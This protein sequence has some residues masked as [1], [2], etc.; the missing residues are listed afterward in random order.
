MKTA[1]KETTESQSKKCARLSPWLRRVL[2]AVISVAVGFG[3]YYGCAGYSGGGLPKP[4][5]V[6][7]A[8]VESGSMQSSMKVGDL[9]I[10][11]ERDEIAVGDVIVYRS[12]RMLVVHRVIAIDGDAI[13]TKGDANNTADTP[14]DKSAYEGTVVKRVPFI[15]MLLDGIKSPI[16]ILLLAA[17]AILIIELSRSGGRNSDEPTAEELRAEIEKLKRERGEEDT[18]PR[19]G[20]EDK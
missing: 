10:V 5:G 7:V 1:P 16:G 2:L 20:E 9:L 11:K 19:G 14:F 17:I 15:G 13:T 12:G 6:G 8:V 4:F 3:A 18:P